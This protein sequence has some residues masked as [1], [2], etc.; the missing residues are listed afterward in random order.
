MKPVELK[1][2]YVLEIEDDTEGTSFVMVLPNNSEE[3]V[4]SGPK[5]WFP[6]SCFDDN[7]EYMACRV[8]RVFGYSYI[9]SAHKL[10]TIGRELL[11]ERPVTKKLTMKQIEDLLGYHVEL[12]EEEDEHGEL[13]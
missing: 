3:L 10:S 5:E 7:L 1:V 8:V 9:A 13:Q 4:I 11:W 2:G 6:L 12:V